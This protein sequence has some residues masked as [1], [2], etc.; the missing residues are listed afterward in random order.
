M[1]RELNRGF[2]EIVRTAPLG[3]C[4]R[5][6]L[7]LRV[8]SEG[9]RVEVHDEW[10]PGRSQRLAPNTRGIFVA[11]A[12]PGMN[13]FG[14]TTPTSPDTAVGDRFRL[15]VFDTLARY[16]PLSVALEVPSDGL[17]EPRCLETSP[18]ALDP[19]VPLYSAPTRVVSSALFGMRADLRLASDHEQAVPWAWLEVSLDGD[20]IATGISDSTGSVLLVGPQPAPREPTLRGSPHVPFDGGSWEV[21]VRICWDAARLSERVPDLCDVRAQPQTQSFDTPASAG[22]LLTRELRAGVPLILATAGDSFLYVAP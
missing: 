20:L 9:L 1:M 10:R 22:A 3:V 8:V 17:F 12:L 4:F 11:H 6:A 18:K 15:S 5:D 7:D 16:V 13:G 21:S 19:H 14:E 2:D